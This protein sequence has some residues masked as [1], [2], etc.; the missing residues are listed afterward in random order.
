MTSLLNELENREC[1]Q[2]FYLHK[3][4]QGIPDKILREMMD[5]IKEERYL[6]VCEKIRSGRPF[7]LPKKSVL[8]KKH[9]MKKRT[10]YTYPDDENEVLKLLTFLLLRKYNTLFSPNLYSFRPGHGAKEA[11]RKLGRIRN[12]RKMY[13]YKA[14]ISNYFNSIDL[15]LFRPMLE[16]VLRDDPE[17]FHFLK[18]L[19]SEEMVID[20]GRPVKEEKGIM[21]GTPLACFYAD[22]FLREMDEWFWNR[23][24]PYA[25]YS[26]DVIVFAETEEEIRM[27]EAEIRSFLEKLH[28]TVNPDKIVRTAPGEKWIFLGYSYE[29]GEIDVAPVSV[30][31][32]KAKMRRKRDALMR[33][34]R[35][36][37]LSGEKAAAA[38]AKIFNRKLF[39]NPK[40][41]DLTWTRWFFP[42]I[43]TEKSLRVLDRYAEDC[44]RYLVSGKHTKAR[45]NVRYAD[46]KALGFRSLVHAYYERD[47]DVPGA[48]S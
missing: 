31:K 46:L 38:F 11:I 27:Y 21:A 44:M 13:S 16:E 6:P 39:E 34:R 43:T 45:F 25:R 9:S 8:N 1:W 17:L 14:D 36:K 30:K 40:H 32:L 41:N 7:P 5:F 18:A 42:V 26:N 35:R 24:I 22:I 3:E 4:S 37:N 23:K 10:V 47:K 33:W 28:L 29:N 48:N 19:L 2:T 15:S 12:I 20:H